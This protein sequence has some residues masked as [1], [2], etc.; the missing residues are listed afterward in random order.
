MAVAV[1]IQEISV[2]MDGIIFLS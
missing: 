1:D 2:F